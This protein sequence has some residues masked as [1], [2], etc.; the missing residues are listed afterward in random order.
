MR[1]TGAFMT[2]CALVACG[3][4]R[5]ASLATPVLSYNGSNPFPAV[6]GES[7]ALTPAVSGTI[8]HY[9]VSPPLPSGL[10]LELK[11]ARER[12]AGEAEDLIR[13]PRSGRSRTAGSG[14]QAT[15]A[16]APRV[17]ND[18][19]R[20][21]MPRQPGTNVVV[22]SPH[23]RRHSGM[24]DFRSTPDLSTPSGAILS[25]RKIAANAGA[26]PFRVAT[27]SKSGVQKLSTHGL[28]SISHVQALRGCR[29]TW[30]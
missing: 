15:F 18:V 1:L 22:R 16:D 8:G 5:Q 10:S 26:H 14:Q 17:F 4:G 23:I 7:I 11:A 27:V 12:G 2:L 30:R 6:I 20:T 13:P 21:P 28:S 9:T 25:S 19:S 24:A 3:E 29:R